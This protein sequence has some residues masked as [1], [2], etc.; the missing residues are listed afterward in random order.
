M[1]DLEESSRK[2]GG[3]LR[4]ALAGLAILTGSGIGFPHQ[5]AAAQ[6]AGTSLIQ[7]AADAPEP[8]TPA[9]SA[10][11]MRLPDGFS[12]SLVAG[13]PLIQDPS[14]IAFDERGRLFVCELHGYNVEGELDVRELNKTG[15][16]DKQVRRLRWEFMG[17]KIAREAAALQFGVVKM[18]SDTDGDGVMDHAEVWADD[19]PPCYGMVAARG[20]ILVVCAPDIVFLADRDGDGRVDTREKLFTGFRVR[21]LERGINN[22]RWGFDHWIYVGGGGEGGTITGPRLETP[23][24]LGTSDFRIKPDGSAI[25]PVTG[26]VGTFGL[27]INAV[28]DR[29]P[30]SGGTPAVYALPIPR[31][32]LER[33]PFVPS[34]DMNHV[35][36]SYNNGYRLSQPHPWRVKRRQDPEWIKFYG[37]R[38]TDSNYFSGG[39]STEFYDGAVFPAP[40]HGNLFYCEPSLNIVHRSILERDGN[41]YRATRAPAEEKSEFLA[42]TDQWFRPMSLRFGPDGALYIVDMYREIIEDYSA[43]PRFL[44][45]Q[46]GLDRGREHGRIW[47]LTHGDT[48]RIEPQKA[49]NQPWPS[50]MSS[51]QLA[52]RIADT[53]A[54]WRLTAQRLLV[55]RNAAETT[56]ILRRHA[57]ADR[58]APG[59]VC[60]LYT[61]DGLGTLRIHDVTHALNSE[62]FEVRIH[63]LRLADR[64]IGNTS[65]L[66]GVLRLSNDPDSRVR[67]QAA[68][69]LGESQDPRA[70]RA[71]LDMARGH[72]HERWMA[73]AI[74]SS[75]RHRADRL[76]IGLLEAPSLN[77][78]ERSLLS[79][80]AATLGGLGDQPA[81]HRVLERIQ[82]RDE[83]IQTACLTGL[84]EGLSGGRSLPADAVEGW[85]A[86]ARIVT[87][88]SYEVRELAARLIVKLPGADQAPLT[89]LFAEAARD[90]LN[91]QASIEDRRLAVRLLA[92]APIELVEGVARSLTAARQPPSLQLAALNAVGASNDPRAGSVLLAGW[93][94]YSPALRGAAL[95][96]VMAR[97]DRFPA[98]LQAIADR[99]VLPADLGELQRQQLTG[100]EDAAI[101]DR[102]RR[103]LPGADS[104]RSELDDSLNQ[105][106]EALTG[107]VDL[108]RGKEVFAQVCSACHRLGEVGVDV[109]PSLATVNSRPDESILLD[110]LDPNSKVDPEYRTYLITTVDG[111][112]FAGIMTE[113][114]PTSVT[115]REAQ[116]RTHTILRRNIES[117][118][119]TELSLMPGN[120]A[121]LI[122]PEDMRHLLG[123]MRSSA[124]DR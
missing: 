107:T 54:W 114:S 103:L 88:E 99:R 73:D 68:L 109:G 105:Y 104:R 38:E 8:M 95:R 112:S 61:L 56:G 25:E 79:P 27:T 47:R 46:Y 1:Q 39:C 30:S 51:T 33:N 86:L 115:L 5:T 119:A 50:D 19:L 124:P 17:G 4:K 101:A 48:D 62:F 76:I 3:T 11:R 123:Y 6:D 116:D 118:Q 70:D 55:E 78:A 9:D 2:L 92:N 24:T 100:H 28:G 52:D 83:A 87:S 63:G 49:G 29:F 93:A 117:L 94:G 65:V 37:E 84:L 59:G 15:R 122:R 89:A 80:L 14:G 43:I 20:G 82:T 108:N 53:E 110:L 22:P 18:L 98:L 21:T 31:R 72:G 91:E 45:Q 41:G 75:A 34:P 23:V 90:A 81:M 10:A 44:Q 106:R 36:S 77:D 26:R 58:S 40:F 96:Q 67:L 97:E 16:L 111:E 85:P 121:D 35:A 42:S 7:R 69:S 66:T 102:A 74:L 71:L 113:D 57:R 13:E 12:V 32:Y 120:L 60:A 64:W